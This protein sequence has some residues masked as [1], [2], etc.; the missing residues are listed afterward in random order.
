MNSLRSDYRN[1]HQLFILT[2]TYGDGGAPASADRFLQRLEDI[3]QIPRLP[4]AIVGFGDRGFAQYCRFAADAET[5]MKAKG[6][7]ILE[8]LFAIDRRSSTSFME[9]GELIGARIG[10]ELNLSLDPPTPNQSTDVLTLIGRRDYGLEVQAPVSIFR[11]TASGQPLRYEAGDLLGIV[12]PG[13]STPRYYSLASCTTDGVIEICV[14]KQRGGLCSEFLHSLAG[15]AEVHAFVQENPR[16]RPEVGKTPIIMI[17]SGTGIAPLMGFV[18]QNA[19]RRDM[20][21]YWGGRHPKS[22]FLY[23]DSLRN[24]L[25]GQRLQRLTTAFSRTSENAYVQDRILGDAETIR[26]LV[27]QGA[28]ILVCGGRDMADGVTRAVDEVISPLGL[29]VNG[30]K[31]SQRY[32]EDVY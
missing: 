23:E 3:K 24:A 30:L 2:S 1:A 12:P 9:W 10:L 11:F 4:V 31:Q 8:R 27:K 16:F 32:L 26:A 20:Y 28:Q 14:R 18:R 15:G 19:G 17:A 29:D 21:L 5:A 7:P 6:W 25:K 13:A 22:D